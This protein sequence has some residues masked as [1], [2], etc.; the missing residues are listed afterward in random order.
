MGVSDDS[1]LDL[2]GVHPT[3]GLSDNLLDSQ[4]FPVLEGMSPVHLRILNNSSNVMH[5][6]KDVELLHE[7]DAPHDLYFVDSGKIVIAKKS[8]GKLKAL[9][10][11]GEGQVFGEFG[12]LRKKSRYASVFT[13]APSRIIRVDQT[14]VNQ[15]LEVDGEFRKRLTELMNRRMLGTFFAG[16]PVFQAMPAAAAEQLSRVLA[17][18]MVERGEHVFTQGDAPKGMYLILSGEVEVRFLNKA[19][20]EVLLEIRRD[21]DILG[22]VLQKN[23]TAFAYTAVAAGDVDLLVLDKKSMQQIRD[24]DAATFSRLEKYIDRRSQLTVKRLKENLS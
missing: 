16:H 20:A 15:V 8:G 22:E 9:Q 5:V 1:F 18:T 4:R 14:A 11:L 10:T 7:G 19:G 6:S 2:S 24:A 21:N 23:G 17:L 12:V 13:A 3:A